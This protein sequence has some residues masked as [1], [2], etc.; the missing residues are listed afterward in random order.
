MKRLFVR[1][2]LAL[3][4]FSTSY[5][6]SQE[7]APPVQDIRELYTSNRQFKKTINQMLA[8]V[9]PLSD[10][11]QNPWSGKNFDDLVEF[12]NEWYYFLPTTHDGLDR[13]IEF[14]YL[15]YKNPDGMKF[16]LEEP[17][18]SWSF[19][20]LRERG[21]FMDSEESVGGIEAWFQDPSFSNADFITP[22]G[23]YRSFNEFFTR[24]IKPGVRPI[25]H[26]ND[27]SIL[28]SPADGVINV[29]ANEL[30]L[31]T[32]IPTK[33]GM[34][35]SLNK[36]LGNSEFASKFVGGTAIALFLM[37]TNYHHYH[38]PIA[39]LLVESK[40][41]VGDRLFG[42]P[43]I[44]AIVNNGNPGYNLNYSVFQDFKHGYFIIDTQDYGHIAM[45]PIGL[46]TVGS[47]VF[48]EKF[49]NIIKDEPVIVQK[50]DKLGH[51]AYG[52][53]TVLLIFEKNR[54]NAVTVDQGQRIGKLRQ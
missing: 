22:E 38:A 53:S 25:D 4:L 34:Y 2:F 18:L 19:D 32:P 35:L 6:G 41:D 33:A 15:Y 37:P 52:G 46:Q 27:N 1:L 10:G 5:L 44:P 12:L 48:E 47:V 40:Q 3:T 11:T 39:G 28:V 51:F 13:I 17:G 21:R 16:I 45:V 31:E 54:I 26:V 7:L 24:D 36:L 42:L 14:S 30:E 43:D 29:I 8:N 23:G 50:G 20:F 9:Q 49:Q